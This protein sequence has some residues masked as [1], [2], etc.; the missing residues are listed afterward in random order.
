MGAWQGAP[1]TG[2]V[3]LDTDGVL[4]DSAEVHAA[5]W[6]TVFD[7]CLDRPAAAGQPPFDAAAD[8]RPAL[9]ALRAAGVPCAAALREQGA[10]PVVPD[11]LTLVRTGW[12]DHP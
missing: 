10:D 2:G 3:V 12:G 4:L 1:P 5:A 8:Y 7:A 6:K 9:E 11:L